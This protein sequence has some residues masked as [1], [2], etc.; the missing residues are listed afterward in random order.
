MDRFPLFCRRACGAM[1]AI[2]PNAARAAAPGAASA[3]TSVRRALSIVALAVCAACATTPPPGHG[4]HA[5]AP[6][7]APPNLVAISDRVVTAGQPGAQWL[8]TL[9]AQGY[10]AVV[11]LAPPTV[12]GAVGDE[13]RIVEGQGLVFVNIP[14]RFDRPTDD[15]YERFA[16]VMRQLDDRKVLVHCQANLRA[17]SMT[18]LDRAIRRREDP[19]RAW[20]AVVAVWKPDPVWHAYIEA[21]LRRYGVG[22]EPY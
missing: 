20:A 2:V 11:Y 4:P 21:Q 15:D 10:D 9:R 13:P 16:Q 1:A 7:G 12:P 19:D 5:A 3:L 17:S 8:A 14:I 18:F 6:G 22:F